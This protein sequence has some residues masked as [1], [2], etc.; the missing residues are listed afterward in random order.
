MIPA[1]F[2]LSRVVV[3]ERDGQS[4]A[5]GPVSTASGLSALERAL[6][7]RGW[8]VR[9]HLKLSGAAQLRAGLRGSQ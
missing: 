1:D 7:A 3:A 6:E 5:F 4:A 2:Y 9:G 8:T